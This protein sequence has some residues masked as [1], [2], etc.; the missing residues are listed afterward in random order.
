MVN[1]VSR[2]LA[3]DG[4]DVKKLRHVALPELSTSKGGKTDSNRNVG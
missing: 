3:T 1:K 2:R 4:A